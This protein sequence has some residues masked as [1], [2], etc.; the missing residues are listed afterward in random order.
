MAVVPGGT[1]RVTGGCLP[2]VGVG[3]VDRGR[4]FVPR[5]ASAASL[6][7]ARPRGGRPRA[8]RQ[9]VLRCEGCRDA[10]P[11][12]AR[13]AVAIAARAR[14]ASRARERDHGRPATEPRRAGARPN[15]PP[16]R[17]RRPAGRDG[18]RRRRR[19]RVVVVTAR[20]RQASTG[21][22]RRRATPT[23][24]AV[25]TSPRRRTSTVRRRQ[26]RGSAPPPRGGGLPRIHPRRR[27]KDEGE[28]IS[29]GVVFPIV[30]FGSLGRLGRRARVGRAS[31]SPRGPSRD[32][33]EGRVP[34]LSRRRH[35]RL[36]GLRPFPICA[37]RGVVVH[38]RLRHATDAPG[39]GSGCDASSSRGGGGE[40][41]AEGRSRATR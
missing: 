29:A 32:A 19:W 21:R 39:C 41:G 14:C 3:D 34:P 24:P 20:A 6:A 11:G 23:P 30:V 28:E 18:R 17:A 9:V 35:R 13:G 22:R 38:H 31:A 4:S 15:P 7:S 27:G 5:R 2:R 37:T 25:G 33:R 12:R 40:L 16:R 10:S 26:R 8:R 1:S 36:L